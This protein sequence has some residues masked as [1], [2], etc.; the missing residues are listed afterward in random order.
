MYL[1]KRLSHFIFQTPLIFY[2]RIPRY[3]KTF[4]SHILPN[5][6]GPVTVSQTYNPSYLGRQRSAWAKNKKY[7]TQKRSGGMQQVV[8]KHEAL[9]S[10]S[11]TT[12]E[13]K[14]KKKKL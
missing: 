5:P 1:L 11:S 8:S 13:K 14:K 10:N 4:H 6:L 2:S 3:H 7:P 12:K 9:S